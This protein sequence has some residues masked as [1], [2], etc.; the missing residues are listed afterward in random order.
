MQQPSHRRCSPPSS[1][2]PS[3]PPRDSSPPPA[4]QDE[5][6]NF[7]QAF[8]HVK[9]LSHDCIIEVAEWLQAAHYTPDAI[10]ETS[11]PF[12]CLQELTK[13]P[14]GQVYA[15]RKFSHAWCGKIDAKRVKR[16]HL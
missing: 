13:L 2:P 6:L 5:L 7:L 14:E 4:V 16:K 15:L 1:L 12:E 10:S 9:D 11:L 8:G 3:S